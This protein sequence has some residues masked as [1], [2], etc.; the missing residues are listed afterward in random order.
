MLDGDSD[1]FFLF[2]L[3]FTL[4]FLLLKKPLIVP[5]QRFLSQAH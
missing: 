1:G 3:P 2:V 4:L 5:T